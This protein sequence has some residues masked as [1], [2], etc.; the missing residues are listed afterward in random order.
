MADALRHWT[1]RLGVQGWAALAGLASTLFFLI[2]IQHPHALFFDEIYYVPAARHLI[3]LSVPINDEHPPFAKC[4]I[5]LGMVILGDNHWG[6]RVPSALFGGIAMFGTL[7][8]VWELYRSARHHCAH[9]HIADRRAPA[10]HPVAHRHARYLHDRVPDARPV[11]GRGG[12]TGGAGHMEAAGLGGRDARPVDG[13]Q[14]D[15]RALRAGRRPR[16]PAVARGRAGQ[17]GVEPQGAAARSRGGAGARRIVAGGGAAARAADGHRLPDHLSADGLLCPEGGAGDPF[18][19]LSV[20][21]RQ[22]PGR[23]YGAASIFQPVV[24]MD[25]RRAADLV[26]LR[27]GRG[28]GARRAAA[29][30]P[31]YH[32]GRAS[33]ADPERGAGRQA[34]ELGSVRAD[35]YV[36]RGASRSGSSCPRK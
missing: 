16:L 31:D 4:I 34:Q 32:V 35:R 21:D 23:L 7:M 18:P 20:G 29:G 9:R 17:A 19:S 6:W 26:S 11:A 28:G 10:V 2:N 5:A 22:A 8:F 13:Q 25:H 12:G 3:D 24:A 14:M 15:H 33:R 36:D 1:D 30:Q 27:A